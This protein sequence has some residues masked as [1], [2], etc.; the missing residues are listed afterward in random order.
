MFNIKCR[1][2]HTHFLKKNILL[3]MGGREVHLI[4]T[5]FQ[6]KACDR[7]MPQYNTRAR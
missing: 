5:V 7:A 4:I 3:E 6:E 2:T 1:E